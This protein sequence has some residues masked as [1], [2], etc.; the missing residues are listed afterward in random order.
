M[1]I[2]SNATVSGIQT[3]ILRGDP[4]ERIADRNAACPHMRNRKV[5]SIRQTA[6]TKCAKDGF[7]R[8]RF[9]DGARIEPDV[10]QPF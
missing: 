10:I 6:W 7:E 5:R 8:G 9:T 1:G 2:G 3:G 4:E